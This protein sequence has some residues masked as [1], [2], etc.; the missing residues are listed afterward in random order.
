MSGMSV[1]CK[2][3]DLAVVTRE[4]P[5][6]EANLGRL[7]WVY[8]PVQ[9]HPE[10]GPLWETRPATEEPMAFVRGDGGVSFDRSESL[11]IHPDAW[12][13]PVHADS[14]AGKRP[15]KQMTAAPFTREWL[16]AVQNSAVEQVFLVLPQKD[17]PETLWLTGAELRLRLRQEVCIPIQEDYGCYANWLWFPGRSISATAHWWVNEAPPQLIGKVYRPA[18][19]EAH[20]IYEDLEKD[21]TLSWVFAD[22]DWNTSMVLPARFES[23]LIPRFARDTFQ[24]EDCRTVKPKRSNKNGRLFKEIGDD[25]HLLANWRISESVAEASEPDVYLENLLQA[26]RQQTPRLPPNHG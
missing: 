25:A 2:D 5:G 10:L 13:T 17:G 8:G 26:M 18:D 22:G 21:R 23:N 15:P 3:G 11:V 24:I 12:M 4:E 14:F 6:L 1:N 19:D 16:E 9:E 7:L 20:G